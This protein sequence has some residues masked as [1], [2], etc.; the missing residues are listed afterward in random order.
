MIV[1]RSSK[2]M[3][4]MDGAD[5]TDQRAGFEETQLAKV[6]AAQSIATLEYK[7]CRHCEEA[8]AEAR[9]RG[10][11]CSA[12]CRNDFERVQAATR[13]NGKPKV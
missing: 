6:R 7:E 4:M 12:E 11:F 8:L 9:Q 3:P 13:R 5:L 1:V 10:G 2:D